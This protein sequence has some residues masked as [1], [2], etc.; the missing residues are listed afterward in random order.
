MADGTPRS[1]WWRRRGSILYPILDAS[2]ETEDSVAASVA[3]LAR[4]GCRLVQLRAKALSAREFSRWAELAVASG[5]ESG[6]DVLV[7]DRA[8][9]ALLAGARGVHVGQDDLSVAAVRRVLGADAIVGL[10]THDL[11]QA[12]AADALDVDYVAIGPAYAT[13]S[14][15]SADRPLGPDGIREVRAFVSKPLVAIG[16]ITLERAPEILATGV[17]AVAVI[18]ALRIGANLEEEAKKWM[19]FAR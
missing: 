4:A 12:R 5:R 15:V 3:A 18:S 8:D 16:G 19:M 9:V 13:T 6:I 10:S 11:D 2:D 1:F 14:K 7:N 17:D